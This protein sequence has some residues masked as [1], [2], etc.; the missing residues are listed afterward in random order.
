MDVSL[1]ALL[2]LPAADRLE[3]ARILRRSVGY[4]VP[5]DA[6]VLPPWERARQD[7]LLRQGEPG[8]GQERQAKKSPTEVGL[9]AGTS[10][11]SHQP[12]G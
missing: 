7:R 6:L 1:D 3:L 8:A 11:A 4:P 2:A 9:L 5:V 12:E 10:S